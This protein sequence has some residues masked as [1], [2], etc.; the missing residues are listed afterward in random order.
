MVFQQQED[1]TQKLDSISQSFSRLTDC[2]QRAYTLVDDSQTLMKN[3]LDSVPCAILVFDAHLSLYYG[4]QSAQSLFGDFI[5]HF[6]DRNIN[7]LKQNYTFSPSDNQFQEFNPFRYIINRESAYF[8]DLILYYNK[9]QTP[10]EMWI[11]DITVFDHQYM[12]MIVLDISERK[13]IEKVLREE[14]RIKAEFKS[15]HRILQALLPEKTPILENFELAAR[16]IPASSIGGD[17]YDWYL[18]DNQDL[19][20]NVG[21]VMGKEM[22]AGL[23]M[24]TLRSALRTNINS[25]ELNVNLE[26]VADTLITDFE[27]LGSFTTVFQG[28]LQPKEKRMFYV[29]A[30]HTGGFMLR[31]GGEIDTLGDIN[32]PLGVQRQAPYRLHQFQFEKG[33]RLILYTRGIIYSYNQGELNSIHQNLGKFLQDF[34]SAEKI[35]DRLFQVTAELGQSHDRTVVVLSCIS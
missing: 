6:L 25:H 23:L 3:I 16:C 11:N 28:R 18:N 4:N 17:F 35:V 31:A 19:I 30:G 29:S 33:D 32:L 8:S 26:Q 27:Q 12:A 34:Y 20:L 14:M 2:L 1:I 15:A 13:S 5:N 24:T 22:S 7:E 10:V 9:Q 21:D